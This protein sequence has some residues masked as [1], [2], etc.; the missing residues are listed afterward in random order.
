MPA[1]TSTAS[2]RY[3]PATG[4][5]LSGTFLRY[6]QTHDGATRLGAPLSEVFKRNN[7][8]GSGRS[9]P[10]QWFE[11]GRLEYHAENAGTRYAVQM[12]LLGID[13]LRAR[14]WLP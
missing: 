6:W 10:T 1:F 12:G 3:F 5:S 9:Y 14:G 4:H 2:R 13:A 7:G 8:D 11:Y